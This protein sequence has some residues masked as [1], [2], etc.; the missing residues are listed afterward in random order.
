PGGGVSFEFST[1]MDT[2]TFEGKVEIAEPSGLEWEPVVHGNRS[3]YLDF[4]TQPETA[5]TIVF[6]AGAQDIY[7]NATPTDYTLSFKT[8]KI[9][10]WARLP[11]AGERLSLTSAYREDTRIALAV[12]GRPEVQFAL[13]RVP[14]E[15]IGTVFTGYLDDNS[16]LARDDYL[17]RRW[18]ETLDAAPLLYGA[19]EVL[20]KSEAGGRLPNGVY[21]LRAQVRGRDYAQWLNLG[22]VSANLTLK[23]APDEV[24]V[25]VTD[26]VSGEPLE[27][28]SVTLYAENGQALATGATD[29]NGLLRATDEGLE[30][31]RIVY[32]IA[33]SESVYGVWSAWSSGQPS[34][35]AGYLYTDRPIYRPGETLYYRGAL[36]HKD[37]MTYTLPRGEQVDVRVMTGYGATL[38]FEGQLPL[39][40]FGTF[41]GEIDLPDDAELGDGWIEVRYQGEYL[42][43]IAFTLAEFRVPEYRVEV[44]PDAETLIQRDPL[45]AA[46]T[47]SYYFGGPVS[48]ANMTWYIWGEPAWFEYTGPGRYTFT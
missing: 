46:I 42:A 7:G 21:S 38:L 44:S 36:R 18:S 35:L 24:A 32:A 9:E 8:G 5:Y 27:G 28:V 41:N 12:E 40:P 13:Y 26:L 45:S 47:A 39:S 11:Y 17:V 16:P 22:V 19:D 1:P 30:T 6:R 34:D 15:Q 33:E 3:L 14:T 4:A 23:R 43:Q 25:W 10:P 31:D 2:D 29:A 37:D 48:N 20:L